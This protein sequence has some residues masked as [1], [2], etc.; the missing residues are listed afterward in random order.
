MKATIILRLSVLSLL[1]TSAP[2]VFSQGNGNG[3]G[4]GAIKW[5]ING[6]N[7]SSGDFI[8]TTN[9]LDFIIKSGNNEVIRIKPSQKTFLKGGL[10]LENEIDPL[11]LNGKF[12][13]VDSTG[14]LV[15]VDQNALMRAIYRPST[16]ALVGDDQNGPVYES[17]IWQSISVNT[18]YGY[19]VTGTDCPARVG[20]GTATPGYQLH[21]VG[22][23]YNTGIVGIG[24]APNSTA[25][26]NAKTSR[27][28][29]ICIDHNY[30]PN[31]GYAI[32][33]IINNEQTKGIGIYS[34][35]YNKDVFTVYGNGKTVISNQTADILTLENNGRFTISNGTE[36]IFQL[37]SDGLL[38]GRRI[39]LDTDTWADYVFDANYNLMPLHELRTFIQTENHLPNVP[40]QEEVVENGVDLGQ[41]NVILLEKVE[42]LTLYLLEQNEK[43]EALTEEVNALK[44]EKV[45]VENQK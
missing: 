2:Y 5:N 25:Q 18:Q 30:A 14:Q 8:G 23:T 6:N 24:I 12:L 16:C 41:M 9:N 22:A 42:E 40:S 29:G 44:S 27:Q 15:S 10:V 13:T 19:L 28:V 20:I 33:A 45:A 26:I 36:K 7:A 37:E 3:N 39:K 35:I 17:P 38:R 1:F 34:N 32:K 4:N 43:L 21:V 11:N 31:F